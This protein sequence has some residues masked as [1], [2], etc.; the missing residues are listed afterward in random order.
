M[1]VGDTVE[2]TLRREVEEETGLKRIVNDGFYYS[3]LSNIEITTEDCGLILFIYRCSVDASERI[4][5][6]DEN[7][8][9]KWVDKSEARILL[10]VK[11]PK[12]LTDKLYSDSG[13]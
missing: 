4:V 3:V 1:H 7:T 9:Y 11:Y 8:E 5:L 6:D 10:A 12:D 13:A 2:D